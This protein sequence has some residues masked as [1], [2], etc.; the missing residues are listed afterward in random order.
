MFLGFQPQPPSHDEHGLAWSW[1][2]PLLS[3]VVL[4]VARGVLSFA[5]YLARLAWEDAMADFEARIEELERQC[6]A[7]RHRR[8][9]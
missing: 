7:L 3:G 2:L 1:L 5:R 4:M 9:S 8:Q 6:D